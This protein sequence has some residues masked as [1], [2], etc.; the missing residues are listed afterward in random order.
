[1]RCTHF[2]DRSGPPAG[3][4]SS[5]ATGRRG[6]SPMRSTAGAVALEFGLAAPLL[7]ILAVG[8]A[9]IGFAAYQAMQVQNA[10]EAGALYAAENGW[11]ATSIA[12]A[13]TGAS[14][15]AGISASPAP[16]EFCGCPSATGIASIACT[17]T[18]TSGNSPGQYVQ[19]NATL[20]RRSL[21][22]NSGLPLPA[23]FTAQSVVRLN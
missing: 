8:I 14:S 5:I 1:M 7:A 17:S 4:A 15:L 10:V 13:V 6:V 16:T 19:V 3:E 20:T 22:P 12:S 11:N 21:I 18:C 23:T 9:E 2:H